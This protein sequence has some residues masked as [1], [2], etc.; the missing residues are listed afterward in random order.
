MDN[1][2]INLFAHNWSALIMTRRYKR[3]YFLIEGF[4][5]LMDDTTFDKIT[6]HLKCRYADAVMLSVANIDAVHYE[7]IPNMFEAT[8]L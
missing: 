6:T 8:L 5:D 7:P 2:H 1:E 3:L 4:R